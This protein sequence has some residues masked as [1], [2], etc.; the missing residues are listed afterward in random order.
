MVSATTVTL[1]VN[2]SPRLGWKGGIGGHLSFPTLPFAVPY[3]SQLYLLSPIYELYP[4]L[5]PNLF[6]IILSTRK[7]PSQSGLECCTSTYI[8]THTI[9]YPSLQK[10][11]HPNSPVSPGHIYPQPRPSGR[12]NPL[13]PAAVHATDPNSLR[14]LFQHLP[15]ALEKP[16]RPPE[17]LNFTRGEAP[18]ATC[19]IFNN[20]TSPPCKTSTA[21]GVLS[22]ENGASQRWLAH[23]RTRRRAPYRDLSAKPS[24]P[25]EVRVG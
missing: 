17:T 20:P 25:E 21:R 15:P 4:E 6:Y 3:P 5:L 23:P 1:A 2:L 11:S 18:V 13:A 8:H 14:L 24:K 12:V 22:E 7:F 16:S 19:T 9:P 10:E